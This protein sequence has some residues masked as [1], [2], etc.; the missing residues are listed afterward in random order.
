MT[1]KPTLFLDCDGPCSDFLGGTL[2]AARALGHH[3]EYAD[4]LTWDF[5]D[6]WPAEVVEQ[7]RPTWNDA[8]WWRALPVVAP[9]LKETVAVLKEHYEVVVATS[10]WPS[11]QGWASARTAW[12]GEH[13]GVSERN[14]MV[15]AAKW[16]LGNGVMIE[17]SA[18]NLAGWKGRSDGAGGLG[19][20][21]VGLLVD[22]PYNRHEMVPGVARIASVA[23][24]IN[25]LCGMGWW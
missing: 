14:V 24:A 21:R 25:V 3:V 22:K 17:D 15:G 2:V 12:V 7:L 19:S 16:S 10:P 11:C 6:D 8:S 23:D 1:F 20:R 4:V 5:Y 9:G 18:K 13:L